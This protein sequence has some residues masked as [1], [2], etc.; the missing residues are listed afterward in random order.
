VP[1]EGARSGVDV[2]ERLASGEPVTWRFTPGERR[3]VVE[4]PADLG[5][6][7]H[8]AEIVGRYTFAAAPVVSPSAA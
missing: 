6:G 8:V 4:L 3:L 1:D 2:R 7:R 5:G